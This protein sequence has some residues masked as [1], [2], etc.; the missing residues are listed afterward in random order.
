[1]NKFVQLKQMEAVDVDLSSEIWAKTV[2]SFVAEFHKRPACGQDNLIDA[3]R[4]L[5]FGR[6]AAFIKETW[7]QSREEAEE[8]IAEE[9]KAFIRLK[10]YLLEKY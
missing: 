8:K 7:E 5:W 2:Y 3:L 6:V 4:V 10:P 9:A 1:L